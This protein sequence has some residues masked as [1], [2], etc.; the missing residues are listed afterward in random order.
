MA[1]E[2]F[3]EDDD[4]VPCSRAVLQIFRVADGFLPNWYL[5]VRDDSDMQ[6]L[7]AVRDGIE[8]MRAQFD[9]MIDLLLDDV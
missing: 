5:E 3:N 9:K 8:L 1:L 4:S 7:L 2:L 6:E